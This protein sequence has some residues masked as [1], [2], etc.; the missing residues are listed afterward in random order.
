[1]QDAGLDYNLKY[2]SFFCDWN[3]NLGY[4]QVRS[5][6]IP[7]NSIKI[8]SDLYITLVRVPQGQILQKLLIYVYSYSLLL[9]SSPFFRRFATQT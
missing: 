3:T 6:C 9:N 8:K 5:L 2:T 7:S 1:V 4:F